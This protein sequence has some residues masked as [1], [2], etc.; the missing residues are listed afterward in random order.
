MVEHQYRSLFLVVPTFLYFTRKFSSP[1]YRPCPTWQEM[2]LRILTL[3]PLFRRVWELKWTTWQRWATI[4]IIMYV[5]QSTCA[6]HCLRRVVYTCLWWSSWWVNVTTLLLLQR[7]GVWSD[8]MGLH[9]GQE[10]VR[11]LCQSLTSLEEEE[12]KMS[13]VLTTDI[14]RGST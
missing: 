9:V 10:L 8:T 12:G 7:W 13:S 14:S 1:R 4:R 3:F 6:S 5:L 11:D 2:L